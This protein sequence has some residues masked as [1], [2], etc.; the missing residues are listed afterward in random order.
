MTHPSN[1]KDRWN[2]ESLYRDLNMPSIWTN[3]FNP[4]SKGILTVSDF[5]RYTPSRPATSLLVP[6]GTS[7]RG[8]SCG[9]RTSEESSQRL[10]DTSL[11]FTLAPLPSVDLWMKP[12]GP[13]S[14]GHPTAATSTKPAS[15]AEE[16]RCPGLDFAQQSVLRGVAKEMNKQNGKDVIY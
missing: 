10:A 14:K 6:V 8:R 9:I 15:N 16:L 1:F 3:P 13:T 2:W 12:D 11:F 5:E 4:T 7:S